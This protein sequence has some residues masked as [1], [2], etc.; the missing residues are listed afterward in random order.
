MT[1]PR[2][3]ALITGA[4]RRVGRAIALALARAGCDVAL[5]FHTSRRDAEITAADIRA[6][7]AR[8]A[9]L[10]FDLREVARCGDLV[11]ATVDTLG[12]LDYL[13]NNASLFLR[14]P[15]GEMNPR[16]W[17]DLLAV[18]VVAPAMLAQAAAEP[19]RAAGGGAIVNL[20]DVAART[21][22]PNYPAYSATKAALANVTRSLALALAPEIRV[23]GVAPGVVAPP[24]NRDERSMAAVLDR[25]LLRRA[26]TPE[27][28]AAVVRF[29]LLEA[30][31]ITGAI[32]PVD[33]GWGLGSAADGP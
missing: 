16:T 29:L 12:R 31:Y 19:I 2:P 23:N 15:L 22:L 13:V 30:T 32:L 14:Q 18:N 3:V 8:A 4:A 7:G 17:N 1:D 28:A 5:H 27:E 26:G 24:V 9:L 20:L 10:P 21:P 11:T 33:G 6:L 25:T